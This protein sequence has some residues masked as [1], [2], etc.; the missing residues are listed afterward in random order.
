MNPENI[1]P[2]VFGETDDSLKD[3][4]HSRLQGRQIEPLLVRLS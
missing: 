2:L 4:L 1:V 3:R